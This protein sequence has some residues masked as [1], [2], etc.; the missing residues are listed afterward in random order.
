MILDDQKTLNIPKNVL[1]L[2]NLSQK[3]TKNRDFDIM[4]D[5]NSFGSIVIPK[6]THS[7]KCYKIGWKAVL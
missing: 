1:K 7:H 5:W 2:A 3:A 4:V 6:K